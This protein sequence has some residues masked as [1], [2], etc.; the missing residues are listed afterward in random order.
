MIPRKNWNPLQR[1][2]LFRNSF[3]NVRLS[4]DILKQYNSFENDTKQRNISA[5]RPVVVVILN[6]FAKFDDQQFKK[7]LEKF[8]A[9][10]IQLLLHEMPQDIRIATFTILQ[11][12]GKQLNLV[13][14]EVAT[15][16]V[17]SKPENT[18]EAN[19]E[20]NMQ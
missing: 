8:Y 5:W 17:T 18:N 15:P 16:V 6:S 1:K 3:I 2:K 11:K 13:Q 19:E 9:P 7:Q 4:L 20:S 14:E 10:V 12:C